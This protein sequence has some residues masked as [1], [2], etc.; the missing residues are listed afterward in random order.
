MTTEK[1]LEELIDAAERI[2]LEVRN[3]KGNF[4]G[5][6]CRIAGEEVVMLNKRDLPERRLAVLGRALKEEE[7]EAVY[8]PPAVRQA[9]HD[10]WGEQEADEPEGAEEPEAAGQGTAS[11]H[12]A[13]RDAVSDS[14]QEAP[15]H[16]E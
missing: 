13:S 12:E 5:G 3:E 16:V 10:V 14:S 7:M 2:G 8:L 11:E 6:R 15:A 4:D 1:V 9:L